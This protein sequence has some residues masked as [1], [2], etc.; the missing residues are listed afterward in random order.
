MNIIYTKIKERSLDQIAGFEVLTAVKA[1]NLVEA[2]RRF[3]GTYCLHL[4]GR[5]MSQASDRQE[6]L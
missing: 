3:R 5:R 1:S 4:Q 6:A 2:H